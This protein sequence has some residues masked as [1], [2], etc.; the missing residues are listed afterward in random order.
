MS[1]RKLSSTAG[2]SEA[3]KSL[4]LASNPATSPKILATLAKDSDREVRSAVARNPN[5]PLE[6]LFALWKKFPEAYLENSLRDY[7]TLTQAEPETWDWPKGVRWEVYKHLIKTD[8]YKNLAI[9]MDENERCGFVSGYYAPSYGQRAKYLAKDPSEKVLL[10]LFDRANWYPENRDG[11]AAV[12]IKTLN[13][14]ATHPSL[15]VRCAL[16]SFKLTP[17]SVR[18]ILV[19]DPDAEVRVAVAQNSFR[20]K[21]AADM[22]E[23]WDKLGHDPSAEVRTSVCNHSGI[24]SELIAKL[25]RD[26][27]LKVRIGAAGSPSAGRET[28]A[29]LSNDP[30]D[31]VRAAVGQNEKVAVEFLDELARRKDPTL[32]AAILTNGSASFEALEHILKK[33]SSVTQRNLFHNRRF[34]ASYIH[35][36]F[37]ALHSEV[38]VEL[39][40]QGGVKA[41]VLVQLTRDSDPKVRL[42]LAARLL[43]GKFQHATPTNYKL[44]ELLV[45]DAH[46]EV[47]KKIV[48]DRRIS[49]EQLTRLSRDSEPQVRCE[50][51]KR[52]Y[53]TMLVML[54]GDEDPEV[55]YEA[56]ANILQKLEWHRTY[57]CYDA[58]R[59]LY[60]I[61]RG[62]LVGLTSDPYHQIPLLIAKAA[63]APPEALNILFSSSAVRARKRFPYGAILDFRLDRSWPR[64]SKAALTIS[65]CTPSAAALD[66]YAHRKNRFLRLLAAKYHRTR[67]STLRHLTKDDEKVIREAAKATLERRVG[68]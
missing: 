42:A 25:S 49:S 64:K 7:W 53:G 15:K 47:R 21:G 6:N 54:C 28:I 63:E 40:G 62:A 66:A 52:S 9:L 65:P 50:I 45:R 51:A 67:I 14:L 12:P 59:A 36:L 24:D 4:K 3:G 13:A 31:E 46:P 26:H 1:A 18:L 11:L 38:K 55:R 39:A 23:V 58:Y 34:G 8:D 44:V 60:S 35:R 61:A 27:D 41:D 37:K 68:K 22:R 57:K 10:R 32:Q 20:G 16:A 17:P 5:T 33:C 48:N 56:A 19:S 30:V 2:S 43:I 29:R